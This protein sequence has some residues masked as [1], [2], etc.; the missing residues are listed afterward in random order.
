MVHFLLIIIYIAFIS[1]GLPDALLGAAWPVIQP[2]FDVPVSWMGP[3]SL[4][5]SGGTVVSSLFSDRLC[6]R[7]GTGRVTAFSV[8]MTAVAL[9]GF[10]L[11]R[12]YWMLCVLALPY[13]LGA[14]AVDSCLN[15]YVA[16]HYSGKHMS[17]L[18]CMWGLGAAA[19]PYVMGA[20]IAYMNN[21]TL[22]YWSIGLLQVVLCMFLFI[23]LPAWKKTGDEQTEE[24]FG[25]LSIKEI[26]SIPGAKAVFLTFFCY[27][28]MEQT[29]GQWAATYFFGHIGLSEGVC[30]LLASLYYT[31]ITV[32]R[33]INGFLTVKYDDKLLVRL[34]IGI[35]IAGLLIMLIPFGTA[36]AVI[37]MLIIGLGSAPIYPCVIHATPSFFGASRSQAVIGVEMASAYVG[38]C[39]I[40]PAFGYIAQLTGIW[41]L[42]MFLLIIAIIMCVCHEFAYITVNKQ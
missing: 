38:F 7:F 17:W 24:Q 34:S 35:I 16:I 5:I 26:F 3:V 40:P 30:A 29:A 32:G 11:S 2:Q 20:A 10:A 36:F 33:F 37:G 19:G 41:I 6:R 1:L 18:H 13:G 23:S 9:I 15:N 12:A 27:C 25:P 22:G 21:W 39:V 31:G 42:P 28:A 8:A 14:G 4:L